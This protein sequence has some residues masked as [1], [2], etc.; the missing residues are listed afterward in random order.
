MS[1]EAVSGV[2]EEDRG[3]SG[4]PIQL[5]S[6]VV[7][8]SVS[9]SRNAYIMPKGCIDIEAAKI[10]IRTSDK[11]ICGSIGSQMTEDRRE[12]VWKSGGP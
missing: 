9:F 1:F 7:N 11:F 12:P 2:D 6:G 10:I 5:L 4:G 3:G 8:L